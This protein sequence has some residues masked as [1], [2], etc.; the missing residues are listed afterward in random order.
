MFQ[1]RCITSG[2]VGSAAPSTVSCCWVGA[3]T[4]P[5]ASTA[6]A[7]RER[8]P[9]GMRRRERGDDAE[10]RQRRRIGLGHAGADHPVADVTVEREDHRASPTRRG[11]RGSADRSCPGDTVAA[12]NC[13]D[14]TAGPP[15]G[16]GI[17]PSRKWPPMSCRSAATPGSADCAPQ[18]ASAAQASAA[19]AH[20][21]IR[22]PP[23]RGWSRRPRRASPARPRY[24]MPSAFQLWSHS[25][26]SRAYWRHIDRADDA[27]RREGLVARHDARAHLLARVGVGIVAIVADADGG[28]ARELL[29]GGDV[30]AELAQVARRWRSDRRRRA[31]DRGWSPR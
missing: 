8:V 27:Q 18:P 22:R 24:S 17:A 7:M 5:A 20:A 14:S 30:P 16:A 21:R 31:R 26:E 13:S 10:R 23:A 19:R 11:R 28:P 29:R 6:S 9:D 4:W 1:P 25:I 15:D 12:E 2:P 3:P